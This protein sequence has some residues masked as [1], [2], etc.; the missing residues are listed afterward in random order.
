MEIQEIQ[1]ILRKSIRLLP[2]DFIPRTKGQQKEYHISQLKT[3]TT[4][5][6]CKLNRIKNW[7]LLTN[8]LKK[9]AI[10]ILLRN[11]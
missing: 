4:V 1:L 6:H 7:P 10:A 2:T 5:C 9:A 3:A 8:F 11:K